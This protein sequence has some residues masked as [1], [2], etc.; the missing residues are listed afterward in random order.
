MLG[1]CAP[2]G[3]YVEAINSYHLHLQPSYQSSIP[4][5]WA[6][7]AS[8]WCIRQ[9]YHIRQVWPRRLDADGDTSAGADLVSGRMR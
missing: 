6:L 3:R 9:V 4:Y 7:G 5:Y 8:L 2:T 1:A